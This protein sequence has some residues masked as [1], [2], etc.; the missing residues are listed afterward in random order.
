[1]SRERDEIGE[2]I[3]HVREYAGNDPVALEYWARM[4]AD[5]VARLRRAL[6]LPDR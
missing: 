4:L 2:A 5:E 6:S 3:V 1:M